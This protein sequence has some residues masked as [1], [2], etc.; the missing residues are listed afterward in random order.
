MKIDRP[1]V[2]GH[3]A[4]RHEQHVGLLRRQHR[5]RLV[6]DQDVAPR[7][8][9]PSGSRRAAAR[10]RESCQIRAR[11]STRARSARASSRDPA[12]DRR[13]SMRTTAP[14]PRWSPSMMFSATVNGCDEPEL[15]VHHADPGVERVARRLE[16]RPARRRARSALVGPVEAGEDVRE[17]ALAGAVLA[18]QRVHLAGGGLEVDA[19]VRDDAR[20]ALRDP[21]HR[22]RR[23]G[24]GGG[25]RGRLG[26]S[27]RRSTA[28]AGDDGRQRES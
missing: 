5:R 24:R 28:P 12:L 2:G 10:R 7:G 8:R 27:S 11:G 17:R 9:A 14:A 23:P 4:Q 18:E 3:L 21:A 1:A 20:K 25:A 22:H 26:R 16:A 15:L 13:G 6:E 19:V